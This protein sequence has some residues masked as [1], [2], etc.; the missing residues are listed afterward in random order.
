MGSMP[1][2]ALD[3][4]LSPVKSITGMV[5]GIGGLIQGSQ[6]SRLGRDRFREEQKQFDETMDMSR[7]KMGLDALAQSRNQNMSGITLLAKQRA[8]AAEQYKN[9]LFK[10]DLLKYLGGQG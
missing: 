4:F 3:S 1:N 10:Q 6:A 5:T 2:G 7:D 8:D 9:R